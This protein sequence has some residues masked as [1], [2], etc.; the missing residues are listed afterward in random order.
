[1]I[2]MT[3]FILGLASRVPGTPH[4]GQN[5]QK[6]SGFSKNKAFF[7]GSPCP[8]G[9]P[10]LALPHPEVPGPHR[11]V[12]HISGYITTI[13]MKVR[14]LGLAPEAAGTPP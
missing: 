12:P 3:I 4:G 9:L 7:K 5:S 13:V 8:K 2:V 10:I 6:N 14:I 1:M 11:S